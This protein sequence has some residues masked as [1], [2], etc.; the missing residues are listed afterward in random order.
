MILSTLHRIHRQ[1]NQ[2]YVHPT[3]LLLPC[4]DV[5]SLITPQLDKTKEMN[6][7]EQSQCAAYMA[8][9]DPIWPP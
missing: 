1:F 9:H 3:N 6:I 7:T 5:Q 2:A 4:A 8:E